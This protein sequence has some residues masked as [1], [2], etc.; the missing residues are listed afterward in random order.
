MLQEKDFSNEADNLFHNVQF[1]GIGNF[2]GPRWMILA[3][4][5]L[6]KLLLTQK[7]LGCNWW[8]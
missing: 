8:E 1:I 4:G 6:Y 2:G 3:V 5:I 7:I